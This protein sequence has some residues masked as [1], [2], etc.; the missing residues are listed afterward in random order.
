[1][2]APTTWIDVAPHT[3][4]WSV[5]VGVLTVAPFVVL[6]TTIPAWAI[7]A[8]DDKTRHGISSM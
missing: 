7:R 8:A 4:K 2:G 6:V 1:L 5:S 3:V